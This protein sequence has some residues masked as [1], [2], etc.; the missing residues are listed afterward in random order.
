MILQRIRIIVG[1]AEFEPGTSASEVWRTTNEPPHLSNYYS[2][3][4]Y[5][6]QLHTVELKLASDLVGVHE[7]DLLEAEREEDVKEED[8]VSPD[9]ALLLALLVQPARPLVLHVLV[10]K[11]VALGVLRDEI[12]DRYVLLRLSTGICYRTYC[13][14]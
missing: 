14:M 4:H 11:P 2:L 13:T 5:R 9:G 10:L 1:D 3:G 12:L 7:N 6:S 8:L